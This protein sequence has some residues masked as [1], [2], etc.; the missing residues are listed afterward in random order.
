MSAPAAFDRIAER[1]DE[2][3]TDTP[4]GRAQRE[5]VWRE[6]DPLFRRGDRVLDIGCGT[7]VDAAHLAARGVIVHA[8]DPSPAMVERARHRAANSVSGYETFRAPSLRAEFRC[9]TPNCPPYDGALSNFGALNCAQDLPGAARAIAA[10]VRPGGRVAICV[11]GRFCLWE[12]LYYAA[13]LRFHKAFRRLPGRATSSLGEVYYPTV[14]AL[15]R[16][17]Q[18]S[19]RLERWIGIGLCVPPSYV[20][21]PARLFPPLHALDRFVARLPFF[22]ALADHRLLIFVRK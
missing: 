1:Y 13:T 14:A 17:F 5:Q 18:P 4:A 3:W 8:T 9:L 7:G 2:Q 12:A 20:R 10:V 21:L 11:I 6:I 19:F 22:R 15:R 16:A